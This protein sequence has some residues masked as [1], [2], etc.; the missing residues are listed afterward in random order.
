[1]DLTA[2]WS[3]FF[4]VDLAYPRKSSLSDV[5]YIADRF[6]CKDFLSYVVLHNKSNSAPYHNLYHTFTVTSN[7]LKIFFDYHIGEVTLGVN[8][9]DK[10]DKSETDVRGFTLLDRARHLY[11]A[12]LFHDFNHTAGKAK[13]SFNI[14]IACDALSDCMSNM[15]LQPNFYFLNKP[16]I[17]QEITG[18]YQAV[19]RLIKG[20]QFPYTY[21]PED[22]V[23]LAMLRDADLSQIAT[24][25]YFQ[26]NVIGLSTELD[27]PLLTFI[28]N[29]ISF[30][31]SVN[32]NTT[33]ATKHWGP[34]V[35][36]KLDELEDMKE[37]LKL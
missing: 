10:L 26:Q 3:S 2:S 5:L 33:Y 12:A 36:D 1:M 25:N 29:Q 17:E 15:K 13:D 19:T 24:D 28:D 22:D 20:T 21:P 14:A 32:F 18:F 23:D 6:N 37:L 27:K 30:L 11:V 4:S 31:K 9:Y 7:A 8:N 34:I 35:A 16:D